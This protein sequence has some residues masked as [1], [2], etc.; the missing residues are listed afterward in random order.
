MRTVFNMNR[1]Q[2]LLQLAHRFDEKA[3]AEIYDTYSPGLYRYAV[4]LLGDADTAEECVAESFS[5]FLAAL[6]NGQ[7]PTQFLKSYLY[8][9]SH[10]WIT[11]YY[12]KNPL[13]AVQLEAEDIPEQEY[14][15]PHED[16][17]RE[18]EIGQIRAA[19][20]LL[21]PEQRQVLVLRFL[22]GWSLELVAREM[23]RPVGAIKS[24]QHRALNSMKRQLLEEELLEE[25]EKEW[26][27]DTN[28]TD[29]M[30]ISSSKSNA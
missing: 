4:R 20:S 1:E 8:R 29:G 16:I 6:K 24:L 25:E 18:D 9:I 3:L 11:D 23:K 22:E 2:K 19:L 26:K 12:R 30:P 21:T 5:R 14:T 7:G 15:D 27:T 28:K 13:E 10:N 17:D